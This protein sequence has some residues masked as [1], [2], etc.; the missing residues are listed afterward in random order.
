[1]RRDVLVAERQPRSGDRFDRKKR[2]GYQGAAAESGADNH[3]TEPLEN[4]EVLAR[5]EVALHR[6]YGGADVTITQD[7]IIIDCA[8]QTVSAAGQPVVLTDMEYTI[9]EKI[10][11]T[12]S[13]REEILRQQ[14]TLLK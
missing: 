1:M 2:T 13:I 6:Y 9:I 8:T 12:R 10:C 14:A 5:V 11:I 3:I 7:D 4:E